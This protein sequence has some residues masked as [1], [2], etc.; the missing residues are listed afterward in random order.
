MIK[1]LMVLSSILFQGQGFASVMLKFLGE[2]RHD[3][4]LA[5][6]IGTPLGIGMRPDHSGAGG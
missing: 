1:S 6:G 4:H 2:E 5:L 3:A